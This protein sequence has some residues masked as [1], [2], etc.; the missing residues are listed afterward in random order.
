MAE[1]K[2]YFPFLLLCSSIM[3]THNLLTGNKMSAFPRM[4]FH[5]IL[6]TLLLLGIHPMSYGVA[7]GHAPAVGDTLHGAPC[8]D[9]QENFGPF[10]YLLRKNLPGELRI[11]EK[12]HFTPQ[13]EQLIAPVSSTHV[14]GEISYT[15]KA[16]PNHHRA[17]N[18]AVIHRVRTWGN[19][20]S[21]YLKYS[22][23]ECWLQRAIKFS[24]KDATVYMLYG[25]LLHQTGFMSKA[26]KNY[27]KALQLEP[28]NVQAQY[29]FALLLAS[30]KK[31]SEAK[32]YALELYSRG[33]PL[34]GLKEKLKKAGKWSKEDE[35]LLSSGSGGVSVV[36]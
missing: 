16:W 21:E 19:R 26:A 10:D 5:H 14:L 29:N 11:V 18:S 33:Y 23:A 34:P 25:I 22:P 12:Y 36:Q 7:I 1:A 30:Q 32:K 20:P 15:L 28:N 35:E 4:P 9:K 17:L 13:V 8:V 6:I 27:E 31:Y 3:P 2:S 24:P